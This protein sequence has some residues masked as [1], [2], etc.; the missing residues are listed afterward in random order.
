MKNKSKAFTQIDLLAVIFVIVFSFTICIALVPSF[1]RAEE[2]AR[3]AQCA[4]QLR[5]MGTAFAVYAASND[6]LLPWY[7]GIDPAYKGDFQCELHYPY[8]PTNS[9][10]P[11]DREIHPFLAYRDTSPGLCPDGSLRPFRLACLYEAGIISD[12]RIFYCPSETHP[13]YLYESY[14]DPLP[15]NTSTEWGTLPQKINSVTGA[16][17]NQWVRV[18]Y[19]YYPINPSTPINLI[20]QAPAFTARRY[21]ELDAAIPYLTDRIW[22]RDEPPGAPIEVLR[23]RPKP[24]A[25]RTADGLYAVNALFKDGHVFFCDDQ[26]PFTHNKWEPFEIGYC[27]YQTFFYKTYKIIGSLSRG[28]EPDYP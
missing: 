25:H 24:F 12:P 21:S 1:D 5:Q 17:G 19:T 3:R 9:D 14:T 18:G 7:G 6:G 27:S 2:A 16:Y 26:R 11:E 10:C 23:H 20:W 28:E 22:K 15:P 4:N 8:Y 13:Q